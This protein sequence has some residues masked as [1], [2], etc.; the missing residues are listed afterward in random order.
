[1]KQNLQNLTEK[2]IISVYS[3]INGK[4]CCGCSGN[5]RYNPDY[6][7]EASK[8]RGYDV[9]PEETNLVM[10]K[11]VLN[12]LKNVDLTSSD[13]EYDDDCFSAVVH[14]RLYVAYLKN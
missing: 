7:K 12:I 6:V 11:K 3:G 2:D 5:H 8:L 4:C 10:I 1:M 9:G 13:V 14:N